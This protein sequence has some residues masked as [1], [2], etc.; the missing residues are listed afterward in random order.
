MTRSFLFVPGDS[1]RKLE[2]AG[3][4]AADA[5][6]VDLEDAVAPDA[7]PAARELARDFVAGRAD[8][9]VRVNPL[10]GEEAE[11]ALEAVMP[12]APAGIVLPKPRSADDV[13]TLARRLDYFESLHGLEPGSTGILPLVTER[14]EA[15][16][17]LGDYRGITPRLTG[18]SWGAE[19]LSAAVG[20]AANRDA[21]GRW[22]PPY[23]LARSLCLF[24]AAAA[25]VAAVDTVFTDY[26]DLQGLA[27]YAAMACRDGF[28]AMLAIHPAQVEIINAAF[29]PTA[30]E[31]DRA[32]RI[33]DLF[34]SS[35]GAGVLGLDGRMLDRPHLVQAE[36]LL[37]LADKLNNE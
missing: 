16:F 4:S 23:E 22:L 8:A 2:R 7:K 29:T 11:A 31:V 32:R 28:S 6:I 18:L 13:A 26:R 30:E 10:D 12:A 3:D 14:P 35:P 20:A 34:A 5:L 9:W 37:A 27:D 25:R 1:E 24:A 21:S 17:N 36:R 15:L 33:V 19:D